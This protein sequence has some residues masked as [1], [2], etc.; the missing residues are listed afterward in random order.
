MGWD[1]LAAW[2]PASHGPALTCVVTPATV[3]TVPESKVLWED[4]ASQSSLGLSGH[5]LGKQA[6]IGPG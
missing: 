1:T 2:T 4:L 3:W 5:F 6:E